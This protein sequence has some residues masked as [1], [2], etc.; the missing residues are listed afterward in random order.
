M[1]ASKR[2]YVFFGM[3]ATGKSYLA[4]EWAGRKKCLYLNS[5]I[6]R[7]ELAGLPKV[8]KAPAALDDGIYAHAFTQFTY[9]ELLHR[10]EMALAGYG[11]GCVVLDASYQDSKERNRILRVFNGRCRL[12][13]IYCTCSDGTVKNRLEQR[14]LDPMAVSD[15]RWEIYLRQKERFDS[16]NEIPVQQLIRLDTEKSL[17][18]LI[19]EMEQKQD[20][21]DT[22][23]AQTC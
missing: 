19:T 3:I 18:E 22:E 1:N 2:L 5:D 16:P 15:G 10:A 6:V 11:S 13:F 14:A 23:S 9:D 20:T 7:K 4:S 8:R 12:L 17:E 21:L